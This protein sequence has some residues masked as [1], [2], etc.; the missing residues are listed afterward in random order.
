MR[1]CIGI[2]AVYLFIIPVYERRD[3]QMNLFHTNSKLTA[4]YDYYRS[5]RLV[6]QIKCFN[7]NMA[8]K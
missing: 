8:Y 3:K 7:K 2:A 6:K 5:Q 1:A 4:P